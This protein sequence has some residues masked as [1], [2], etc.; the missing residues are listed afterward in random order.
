VTAVKK[1]SKVFTSL[2]ES[3][4]E[5][6]DSTA[7]EQ[8]IARANALL[9]ATQKAKQQAIKKARLSRAQAQASQVPAYTDKLRDSTNMA[10]QFSNDAL[11]AAEKARDSFIS[12]SEMS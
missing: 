3:A 7:G 12:S 10:G 8:S 11:L 4:T 2:K 5:C 6:K 1:A 9:K